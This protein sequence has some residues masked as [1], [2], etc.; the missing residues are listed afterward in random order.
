[1]HFNILNIWLIPSVFHRAFTLIL[2]LHILCIHY[3]WEQIFEHIW[4]FSFWMFWKRQPQ[5]KMYTLVYAV[6]TAF[7]KI[8]RAAAVCHLFLKT[9]LLV[10]IT[11]AKIQ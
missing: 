10:V 9:L 6:G 4:I 1:M 7:P 11:S 8:E 3:S 5:N 2:V